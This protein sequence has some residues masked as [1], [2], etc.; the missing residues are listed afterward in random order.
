M[1]GFVLAF[2][3]QDLPVDQSDRSVGMI[4]VRT[5]GKGLAE[6]ALT[7]VRGWIDFACSLG[8]NRGGTFGLWCRF[9]VRGQS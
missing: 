2:E 6:F 3:P 7:K 5:A 8:K 1:L 4:T 9:A